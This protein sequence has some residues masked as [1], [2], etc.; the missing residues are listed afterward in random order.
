[1]VTLAASA[2]LFLAIVTGSLVVFTPGRIGR[3]ASDERV[4]A[5]RRTTGGDDEQKTAGASFRQ[6]RSSIPALGRLLSGSAWADSVTVELQQ[7]NVHLRAGEYLLGRL[8]LAVLLLFTPVLVSGFHPIGLVVG[9]A[10]GGVGYLFPAFYLGQLRRRRLAA[11]ERQLIELL[12]ML[13][14]ALRSGFA[15]QQGVELAAK[16]L[17]SPL[18]DELALLLNDVNLGATMEAALLDFGQRVGSTDL[19]MI[20]TA[21]LVQQASGGNLAEILDQAAETLRER[22]RIRG[23]LQTLTAQQRMT[24][25]ILSVY[26]IAIG[27]LLLAIMPSMWSVLF[28]ETVGRVFLGIALGLQLSGF[29]FIRRVMNIEI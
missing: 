6:S 20:I 27:L 4:R 12:P 22:E 19:D 5:L 11:I 15:F 25:T 7:A 29:F 2:F 26:P 13:A 28:T 1:M 17:P 21:I 16:Q 18:A 10:L 3:S 9:L 24:G 23:D 14:S 8:L